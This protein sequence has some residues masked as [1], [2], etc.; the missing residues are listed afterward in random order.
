MKKGLVLEGGGLRSLFSAGVMDVMMENAVSFD[1]IIGVSAGAC[2]GCNYKSGQIGR[3]LRYNLRFAGDPRYMSWHSLLKEG[4][5]VSAGFA[6]HTM[7][8]KLDVFD[9]CAYRQNPTEFY[10]VCTDIING[11]AIYHKIDEMDYEGLEWIRAS[12][13]MPLVS[14]PVELGGTKLLDGG[15]ADSIPLEAFNN[16]GYKRNIVILTQPSDYAK[17]PSRLNKAFDIFMHGYPQ[18][19]QLMKNRYKMYN[20]QLEYVRRQEACGSA[21]VICPAAPLEISRT[22]SDKKQMQAVYDQGRA[23][24][25]A[26]IERIKE[27]LSFS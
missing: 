25:V 24:G 10:A 19:Y 27:F 8:E 3:S 15:M 11:K 9:S 18:V 22:S 14:R 1:G 20:G 6:Y 12:S 13:S 17:H 2:F 23:A 5:L 7:P 16:M 4:N 26:N 21:L